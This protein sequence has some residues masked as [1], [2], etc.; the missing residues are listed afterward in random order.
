MA[1]ANITAHTI[2]I[3]LINSE[4]ELFIRAAIEAETWTERWNGDEPD[5]SE[6][7]PTFYE[8]GSVQPLLFDAFT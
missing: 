3:S 2:D 4:E 7:F 5:S 8:D 6:W 1:T